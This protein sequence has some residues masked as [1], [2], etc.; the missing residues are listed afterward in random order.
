MNILFNHN[1]QGQAEVKKLLGF[2]SKDIKFDNLLT[3]IE[4]NTPY[5]IEYIGQ[6]TYDRIVTFYKDADPSAEDQAMFTDVL[7]N[8]Q[9]FVL[10]MAY[11]N[12]VENHD[13]IH[14]NA[15]RKVQSPE[16]QKTPWEWQLERDSYTNKKRAYQA[17]DSLFLCLDKDPGITEWVESEEFQI[18]QRLF[19][20][21]TAIMNSIYPINHSG[22]LYFRLVKFMYDI[23]IEKIR[24]ILTPATYDA[25]VTKMISTSVECTDDDKALISLAQK[26]QTYYALAQA[27]EVFPVEMLPLKINFQ[28]N[29]T[30]KSKA[31]A[32]VT[33]NLYNRAKEY[34]D[35]LA[36][37]VA[38][39][40]LTEYDNTFA[41]DA[42]SADKKHFSV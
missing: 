30:M 21:K 40:T 31:R 29:T 22:L 36:R 19:V 5:L 41:K 39:Q 2:I 35:Q 27:Y 6:T 20:S 24:P 16:N 23:Q 14:G 26:V 10:L 25:L 32:E 34:E 3:D 11:V 33:Q 9:L 37:E 17:L 18:S 13:L 8:A 12:F 42:N 15:G 1:L 28:E 4:L 38:S 7:K